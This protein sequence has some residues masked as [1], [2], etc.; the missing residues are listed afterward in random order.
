MKFK[1]LAADTRDP[2]A[3]IVFS[4]MGVAGA[5]GWIPKDLDPNTL[6]EIVGLAMGAVAGVFSYFHHRDFKSAIH[7]SL[8][9]KEQ[10]KDAISEVADELET[11]VPTVEVEG[12]TRP[13]G[14]SRE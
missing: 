5:L 2:L 9:A 10:A 8:D 11:G 6:A 7:A 13:E 12:D 3:S 4:L 14:V 1:K